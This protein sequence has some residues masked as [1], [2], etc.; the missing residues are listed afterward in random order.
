MGTQGV[1][2]EVPGRG[3]QGPA[4]PTRRSR[5]R[6]SGPAGMTLLNRAVGNR[7][8]G[9]LLAR[10]PTT[11]ARPPAK[12]EH[13][14]V[15][16]SDAPDDAIVFETKTAKLG[17]V[18]ASA[19][20][21]MAVYGTA[22]FDGETIPDEATLPK[23]ARHR[24][25]I[26]M[27][28][29]QHA[30][31]LATAAL[32]ASAPA[33]DDRKVTLDVGGQT[34]TLDL[35]GGLDGI[36]AFGITGEFHVTPAQLK[37]GGLTINRPRVRLDVTV[38][39]TP[40][41]AAAGASPPAA[42]TDEAHIGYRFA[43]ADARFSDALKS[44]RDPTH[45]V[46]TGAIALLSSVR[47]L[48]TELHEDVKNHPALKNREQKI[49]LLQEMRPFFGSDDRTVEHFKRL[50]R[51][52]LRAGVK[53]D[54]FMHD[55]AATRLEAVR[56]EI[57]P[58]PMPISE[59]GWPRAEHSLGTIASLGNP[60][61][62]GMA[63]DFNS[64]EMPHLSST[65]DLDLVRLISGGV[66]LA[67]PE[68]WTRRAGDYD[69]MIQ[70][71]AER[72]HMD[73][74]DP[75]G[76]E[77]KFLAKTVDE[78]QKL[79]TR[80][81]SFRHSLDTTDASGAVVDGAAQMAA[82]KASYLRAKGAQQPWA[83]AERAR[84]A[85]LIKPWS[86]KIDAEL[87]SAGRAAQAGGFRL[88]GMASG[89]ALSAEKQTLTD[90]VAKAKA[91]RHQIQN[92]TPTDRQATALNTIIGQL[93]KLLQ[94]DGDPAAP[95]ATTDAAEALKTLADLLTAA[96]LRLRN[97][98]K[99]V[100]YNRVADLRRGLDSPDWVLGHGGSLDVVDPSP[101]QML[102]HGFFTLRE[103]SN[104][105]GAVTIE[106]IRAMVKHGFLMLAAWDTPDYMHFELRWQGPGVRRH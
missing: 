101:D 49:A 92:D 82:L 50:R 103:H 30:R 9:G 21:R 94:R 44:R 43:G 58:Q 23:D 24:P 1:S 104:N 79:A 74:P 89:D 4:D 93:R 31:E 18:E 100:W 56:D 99:A 59:I 87:A 72:G 27:W 37:F 78:A 96:D 20:G 19:T 84:Y 64:T 14:A 15:A 35:P 46:R 86:D 33:G 39:I 2:K 25:S 68:M 76:A 48:E 95:D 29:N 51:V 75:A 83:D 8:L 91:L 77:G 80:S 63:V 67:V 54:L 90:T 32:N 41:A 62:L 11:Q 28:A 70:R 13:L 34:L 97:Y 7:A 40:R 73:D 6:T 106:F 26:P 5:G 98:G 60:H 42:F 69:T 85:A 71:T 47:R 66:E 102:E 55:E 17:S 3:S 36:P 12:A 38:W 105:P 45:T 22:D 16:L 88:Q 61:N 65:R 53:S 57:A 81:E 10:E 52:F